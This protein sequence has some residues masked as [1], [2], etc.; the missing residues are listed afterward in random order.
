MY[1]YLLCL[2]FASDLN[3]VCIP[4]EASFHQFITLNLSADSALSLE[5]CHCPFVNANSKLCEADK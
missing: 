5:K 4:S 2:Y 3:T 1:R